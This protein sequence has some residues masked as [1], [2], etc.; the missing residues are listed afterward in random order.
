LAEA[1]REG[2]KTAD[3]LTGASGYKLHYSKAVRHTLEISAWPNR[4]GMASAVGRD[5]FARAGRKISG[6]KSA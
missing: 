1:A 4:V 5:L 2:A 3:F 6:L